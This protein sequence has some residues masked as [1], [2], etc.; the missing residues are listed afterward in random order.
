MAI[1]WSNMWS[2]EDD[3]P[4]EEARQ[5]EGAIEEIAQ[6]LAARQL[7]TPALW[8][9]ESCQPLALLGSQAMIFFQPVAQI[10]GLGLPWQRWSRL[11]AQRSQ[12][13]ALARRLEIL[14]SER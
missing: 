11:L 3:A 7:G 9:V 5:M 14:E 8:L 4:P 10:L 6:G 13:E 1:N 12:V 2:L